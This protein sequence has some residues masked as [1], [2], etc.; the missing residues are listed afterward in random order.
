MQ[1]N[2]ISIDELLFSI[3]TDLINLLFDYSL[4]NKFDKNV[5]KVILYFLVKKINDALHVRSLL[6]YHN[7]VLNDTHELFNHYPK[8]KL[9]KFIMQICT[10]IK[11]TTN[12]LFFISKKVKIP[13]QSTL[14]LLDGTVQDEIILLKNVET[15]NLKKL[16]EFLDANNLKE[17]FASMR[18]SSVAS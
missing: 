1:Y 9:N 15:P 12:R 5:K 18:V 8:D 11:R 16:K 2:F 3:E 13:A 17:L 14:D 4:L 6:I 10:T 7:P